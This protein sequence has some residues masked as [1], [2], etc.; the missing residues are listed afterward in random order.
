MKKPLE[1]F[2]RAQTIRLPIALGWLVLLAACVPFIPATPTAVPSPTDTATSSPSPTATPT[3][4]LTSTATATETLTPTATKKW[5]LTIVF[6]GDSMLKIGEVGQPAKYSYS[7]VDDLRGKL[8]PAYNLITENHG[9]RDAEWAEENLDAKVLA[10]APDSVTLWWGF[11]DLLGCGGIFDRKTN[12]LVQKNLD[13]LV[14][15]HITNL[16]RIVDTLLGNGLSVIVLTAVPVD[17]A[18]PWTHFDEKGE[19]VWEWNYKCNYNA[20]LEQ[21][22][23]AQRALVNGYIDQGFSIY[24]LDSWQLYQDHQGEE[25]M[26][27][28]LIHPGFRAA[29]LLA[30]DWISIFA[31]TGEIVRR[32]T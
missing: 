24:L 10:F 6:Y 4:S 20:G 21:L 30:E 7:F 29:M 5:P 12:K 11:N 3:P 19:L 16:R 18:L 27:L 22:A 32:R 2:P 28:D 14:E 1:R 23:D 8:D 25:G 9:G 26:Y 31:K 15:H 17:G 13:Q